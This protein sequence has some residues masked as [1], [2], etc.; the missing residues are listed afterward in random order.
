MNF[1]PQRN[2]DKPDPTPGGPAGN[3]SGKVFRVWRNPAPPSPAHIQ[4]HQSS[5]VIDRSAS[6]APP[7]KYLY[8]TTSL[9]P[10][11]REGQ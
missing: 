5:G 1:D 4:L 6:Q 10:T 3:W 11:I 9:C 7:I 8:P 2:T